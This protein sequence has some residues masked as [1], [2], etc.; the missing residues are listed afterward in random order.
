MITF[1]KSVLILFFGFILTTGY[2]QRD[3]VFW[4]AAPNI[5]AAVGESPIF[6]TVNT[7]DQAS[8]VTVS[9][10]ANGLF[11]PIVTTVPANTT[12]NI[13]LTSFLSQIESPAANLVSNNGL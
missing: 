2:S 4:F 13:D 10:P 1:Q 9:I 12:Q 8:T 5:S 3:S 7:Y 6:L 11:I